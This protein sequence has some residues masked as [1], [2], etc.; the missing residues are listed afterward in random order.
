VRTA[1]DGRRKFGDA[2]TDDLKLLVTTREAAKLLSVCERTVSRLIARGELP[3]VRIGPRGIRVSVE[4]LR[5]WIK[6][7]ETA[8]D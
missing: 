8:A 6:K 1:A 7:K 3:A 2:V 5:K 4:S